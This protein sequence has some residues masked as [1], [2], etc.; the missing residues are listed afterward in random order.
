MVVIKDLKVKQR[1]IETKQRKQ[2]FDEARRKLN[3]LTKELQAT[4]HTTWPDENLVKALF[5]LD[6]E[7]AGLDALIRRIEIL[8]R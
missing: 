6:L 7:I 4:L 2:A 1:Y 5:E 8:G 3:D